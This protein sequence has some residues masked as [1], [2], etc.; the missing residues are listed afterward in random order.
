MKPNRII[1]L[2]PILICELAFSRGQDILACT[3]LGAA[4]N[5]VPGSGVL[6]GKT[7]DL[8][9]REEQVFIK[10]TPRRSG[11]AWVNPARAIF[12]KPPSPIFNSMA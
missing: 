11:S 6:I 9:Q 10:E 7:R 1:F 12:K 8:G 5:S 2:I 3:L 4:G